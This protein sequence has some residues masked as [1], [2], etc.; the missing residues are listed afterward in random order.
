M[1]FGKMKETKELKTYWARVKQRPFPEKIQI[2]PE[3]KGTGVVN[4]GSTIWPANHGR[5]RVEE[6]VNVNILATRKKNQTQCIAQ[7]KFTYFKYGGNFYTLPEGT[8]FGVYA[9]DIRN[10][11]KISDGSRD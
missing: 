11:E 5:G 2:E 9:S 3:V 1:K 6:D 8:K 4:E 10:S 7:E